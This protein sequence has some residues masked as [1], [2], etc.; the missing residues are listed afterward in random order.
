MC[1]LFDLFQEVNS[2]Y[3]LLAGLLHAGNVEFI[4]KEIKHQHGSDVAKKNSLNKSKYT[5]INY[6]KIT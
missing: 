3:S 2:V 6:F 4:T 5:T 1:N